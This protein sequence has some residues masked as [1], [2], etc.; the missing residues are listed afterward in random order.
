MPENYRLNFTQNRISRRRAFAFSGGTATAAILLAACGEGDSTGTGS[1]SGLI[2]EPVDTTKQAKRGGTLKDRT[3]GDP[4]TLDPFTANN[5]QNAIG[6]HCFT[7]LAQFKPA[8]LKAP[9]GELT[10]EVAESWEW[11]PDRLQVTLKLRPGVKWHNKSPVNARLVD[12]DDVLFSWDRFTKKSSARA[13][14]ANVADPEAPVLSLTATDSRT[15]VIKLKEPLFSAMNFFA[16]N[17]GGGIIMLP[18]ETDTTFDLRNDLIGTGPFVMANYT[19]R[20]GS[21]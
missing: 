3:F 18:E 17:R 19:P 9:E 6:P 14:I 10:G 21:H 11:S 1:K 12:M 4:P 20:S 15:L 7:N 8:Y 2:T 16:F 13:S 5:P